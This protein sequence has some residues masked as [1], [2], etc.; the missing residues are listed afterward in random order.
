MTKQNVMI[1]IL[2]SR[3]ETSK[4]LFGD[5]MEGEENLPLDDFLKDLSDLINKFKD[6]EE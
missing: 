2:T 5:E 3:T 1:E 4:S 6:K